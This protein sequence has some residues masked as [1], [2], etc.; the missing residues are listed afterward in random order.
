MSQQ[1]ECDTRGCIHHGSLHLKLSVGIFILP[2]F[3]QTL[4]AQHEAFI[5]LHADRNTTSCF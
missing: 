3:I 5:L 1:T 2:P 4:K